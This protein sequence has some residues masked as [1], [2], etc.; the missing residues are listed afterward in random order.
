MQRTG[1]GSYLY[2][3]LA[4]QHPNVSPSH[5]TSIQYH[6]DQGALLPAAPPEAPNCS[7]AQGIGNSTASSKETEVYNQNHGEMDPQNHGLANSEMPRHHLAANNQQNRQFKNAPALKLEINGALNKLQ[8]QNGDYPSPSSP[9][10]S[11]VSEQSGYMST[12]SSC[13]QFH[14]SSPTKTSSQLRN[15]KINSNGRL[16]SMPRPGM[17]L[18]LLDRF[19]EVLHSYRIGGGLA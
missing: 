7:R 8:I 2:S 4:S 9:T 11:A 5:P 12:A 16:P 17:H 18:H 6:N 14:L 1:E 3:P 10:E 19:T 13:W 15:A